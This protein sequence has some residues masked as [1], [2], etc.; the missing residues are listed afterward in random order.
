MSNPNVDQNAKVPK[1]EKIFHFK[2]DNAEERHTAVCGKDLTKQSKEWMTDEQ[3]R[4]TCPECMKS[5]RIG[6]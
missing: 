2:G 4:V 6:S 5:L 1:S 3:K